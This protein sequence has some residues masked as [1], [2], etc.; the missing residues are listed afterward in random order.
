MVRGTRGRIKESERSNK[1]AKLFAG[2][3]NCKL[4]SHLIRPGAAGGGAVGL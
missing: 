2:Q 4:G 1:L 3:C